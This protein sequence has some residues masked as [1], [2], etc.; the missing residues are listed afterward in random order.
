MPTWTVSTNNPKATRD[1]LEA[2]DGLPICVNYES[3]IPSFFAKKPSLKFDPIDY[4]QL[5]KALEKINLRNFPLHDQ[6][7]VSVRELKR[8]DN[9]E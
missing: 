8:L 7:M 5:D 3:L 1:V 2:D 4:E 9:V 6:M